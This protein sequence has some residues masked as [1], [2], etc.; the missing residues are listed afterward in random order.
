[1]TRAHTLE[2]ARQRTLSGWNIRCNVCSSYGARWRPGDR[3]GWGDLAVCPPC[4]EALNAEHE[5]HSLALRRLRAVNFE[6]VRSA[7][8]SSV[9]EHS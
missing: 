4:D 2:E 6:Q 9:K 3:P 5:R 8:R 7:K 1:M